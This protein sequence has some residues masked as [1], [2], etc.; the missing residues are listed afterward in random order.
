MRELELIT[1]STFQLPLVESGT[2]VGVN[3]VA[4]G[5][6]QDDVAGFIG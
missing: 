3:T 4:V 1:V 2:V 5:D 6:E